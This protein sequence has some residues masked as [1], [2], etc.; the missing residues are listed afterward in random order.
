MTQSNTP[1]PRKE[2]NGLS[3][4]RSKFLNGADLNSTEDLRGWPEAGCAQEMPLQY[5]ASRMFFGRKSGTVLARSAM[6]TD[7]CSKR[8]SGVIKVK[9][10]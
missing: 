6:L 1:K 7:S 9:S 3:K 5:D 10:C 2:I 4:S 8:V